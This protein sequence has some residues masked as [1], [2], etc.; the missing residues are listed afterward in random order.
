M[1]FNASPCSCCIAKNDATK[2]LTPVREL[3]RSKGYGRV[4]TFRLCQEHAVDA[5]GAEIVWRIAMGRSIDPKCTERAM[6]LPSDDLLDVR[7]VGDVEMIVEK[8]PTE[9]LT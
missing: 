5:F 3:L 6:Q 4:P 2:L 7:K 9:C 8:P 1:A